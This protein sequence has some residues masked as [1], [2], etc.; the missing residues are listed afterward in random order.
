V[1][2]EFR[3]RGGGRQNTMYIRP[4]DNGNIV[5]KS[6]LPNITDTITTQMQTTG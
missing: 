6:L 2:L 1:K 4:L 5:Q 3:L